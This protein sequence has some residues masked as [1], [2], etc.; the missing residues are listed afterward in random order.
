MWTVVR[1]L[2][3]QKAWLPIEVTEAGIWTVVRPVQS[4]KACSGIVV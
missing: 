2:Q 3:P 1:P 4:L